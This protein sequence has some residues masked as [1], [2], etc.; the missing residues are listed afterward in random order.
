[1]K[2]LKLN[3][4]ASQKLSEV[5]MNQVKGGTST[6]TICCGCS[7][8]YANSGGSSTNANGSANSK[9]GGL[10]SEKGENMVYCTVIVEK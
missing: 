4:L 5:E 2:N 8:Y 7:C 6:T 3:V 10:I 1:M 9:S